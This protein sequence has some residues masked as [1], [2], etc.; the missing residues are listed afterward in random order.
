MQLHP[1][2][3]APPHAPFCAPM[4]GEGALLEAVRARLRQRVEMFR[5]A[6]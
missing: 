1:H 5:R 2:F 6:A 3:S 4:L